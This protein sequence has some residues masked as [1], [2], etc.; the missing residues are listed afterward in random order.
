MKLAVIS[1]KVCWL[2]ADS[3]SG[4]IT[5]GGFPQQMGAI[6]ELFDETRIVVPCKSEGDT[7]GLSPL[8]GR[9]IKVV[10][11]SEP[12]VSGIARKLNIPFWLLK[13]CLTIF[14]EIRTADAIHSPI[15][16]DVGTIGMAIAIMLRKPLFVRHCGNWMIQRTIAEKIWRWSMEYFA[17]GRNAMLAT[18]GSNGPPSKRNP[19]VEWIFATSL[20]KAEIEPNFPRELPT[21]GPVKLII[22]CRQE[23]R[24]G[25]DVVIDSLPIVLKILP[26]VTLDVVGGGSKLEAFRKQAVRLRV[27]D[28]IT[29][30]GKVIH[31]KVIKLLKN[32]HIFCYPT[33]A[34]EGFPKVVLEAMATGLPVITTPV[35]V[36]SQLIGESNGVLLDE[37]EPT[38]L[39]RAI[40][41][42]CSDHLRY[43][44]LSANA[45]EKAKEFTLESWRELIGKKLSTTWNVKSLR[46]LENVN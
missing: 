22:V 6:S 30:H 8:I 43:R 39:A 4:Y 15:P 37:P 14:R 12:K 45:I 20:R 10:P 40:V 19:H 3:P 11:L 21:K 33:S 25:T 18:G 41:E 23:A 46:E 13:N 29:F 38:A 24:K 35:S 16:G 7:T 28:R 26:N 27:D 17:G 1:H 42:L 9:Q 44:T 34:S 36:L 31:D 32:A 5:D 2:S